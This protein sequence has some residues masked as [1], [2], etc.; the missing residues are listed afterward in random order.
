MEVDSSGCKA[1][2]RLAVIPP[3]AK[4]ADDKNA[5]TGKQNNLSE[6]LRPAR[7]VGRAFGDQ[8]QTDDCGNAS[9]ALDC[10]P[11]FRLMLRH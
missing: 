4:I 2:Q 6:V 7:Y 5:N 3:R 8:H 1:A 9:G 11:F 10:L